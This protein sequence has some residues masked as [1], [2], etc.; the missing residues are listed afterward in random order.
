MTV[1]GVL[2]RLYPGAFR[3]RWGEDLRAEAGLRRLGVA[4]A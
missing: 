1:T 2:L 4:P 3:E